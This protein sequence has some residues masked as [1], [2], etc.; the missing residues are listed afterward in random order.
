M[1]NYLC[2]LIFLL[3]SYF[4]ILTEL[5]GNYNLEELTTGISHEL[6]NYSLCIDYI[7]QTLMDTQSKTV[8]TL[9]IFCITQDKGGRKNFV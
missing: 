2:I 4:E 8:S 5:Y 1:T 6:S 7:Q 3:I 9:T